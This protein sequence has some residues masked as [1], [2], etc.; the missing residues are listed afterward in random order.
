MPTFSFALLSS[1][2]LCPGPYLFIQSHLRRAIRYLA[3]LPLLILASILSRLLSSSCRQELNPASNNLRI[4]KKLHHQERSG[5]AF[6]RKDE[7][8]A[9]SSSSPDP[10]AQSLTLYS[11]RG[12]PFNITM[13]DLDDYVFESVCACINYGAQLGASLLLLVVV[14][15]LTKS[16][17]RKSPIFVLNTLSLALNFV[18]SL[19][20]SLYFNSGFS[21]IYTY[22]SQDY[23]RVPRT[24]YATSVAADV[25]TLLLLISIQCSLILQT[26]VTTTTLGRRYRILLVMFSI[27][28]ALLATGFRLF[29][30]AV[31]AQA[32]LAAAAFNDYGWLVSATNITTTISICFFCLVFAMKLGF[33]LYQRRKLGLR[34]FG[35]MQV[36][37]IMGCQT[38]IIPG[39]SLFM[40]Q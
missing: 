2:Y 5:S 8:A 15:L 7:M 23:S 27:L 21:E 18:R 33:A 10:W 13:I 24:D 39:G 31:N 16:D 26:Q 38:M 19:L 22:F 35:P 30:T 37:F 9:A 6:Q 25:L 40:K 28:M 20:Q 3:L 34:Q 11:A 1:F 4:N 36:I 12:E 17:K 29:L 14:L 32:I